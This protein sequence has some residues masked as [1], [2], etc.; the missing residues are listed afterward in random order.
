MS[1][2]SSHYAAGKTGAAQ[3]TAGVDQNRRGDRPVD[4]QFASVNVG[5]PFV[6]VLPVKDGRAVSNLLYATIAGN[7]TVEFEQVAAIE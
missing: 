4:H 1:A 5:H 3:C 2:V 6:A 7:L